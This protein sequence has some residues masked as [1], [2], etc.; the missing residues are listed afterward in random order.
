MA[1]FEVKEIS[2]LNQLYIASSKHQSSVFSITKVIL[3]IYSHL[4]FSCKYLKY[5]VIIKT[6]IHK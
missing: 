3:N 5:E 1:F 4:L 6:Y 2:A